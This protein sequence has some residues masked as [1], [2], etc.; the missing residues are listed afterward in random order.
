VPTI[1]GNV[2]CDRLAA[3]ERMVLRGAVLVPQRGALVIVG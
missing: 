1:V 3:F 2:S